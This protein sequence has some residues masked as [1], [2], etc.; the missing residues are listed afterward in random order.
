MLKHLEITK[1][2]KRFFVPPANLRKGAYAVLSYQRRI[3]LKFSVYFIFFSVKEFKNK[4]KRRS[5][6]SLNFS[7][8]CESESE[9]EVNLSAGK[10][11]K[12]IRSVSYQLL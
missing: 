1:Q 10:G 7:S 2:D 12:N 11:R 8:D 6:V 5:P 4:K 9:E 3:Y